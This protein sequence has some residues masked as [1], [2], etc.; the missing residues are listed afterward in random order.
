MVFPSRIHIT[1]GSSRDELTVI[2]QA[3]LARGFL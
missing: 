3:V 1:A 2:G